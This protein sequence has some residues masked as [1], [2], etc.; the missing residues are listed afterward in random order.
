MKL[1]VILLSLIIFIIGISNIYIY[2]FIPRPIGVRG[3]KGTL[4]D[5]GDSGDEGDMGENGIIGYRGPL[6]IIGKDIGI[7]GISGKRGIPG[8]RGEVG[9]KGFK[10]VKGEKGEKGPPG[11]RGPPGYTGKKG[12][13]G[14]EG[15]PREISSYDGQTNSITNTAPLNLS[16]DRTKCVQVYATSSEMKCPENMAVFDIRARKVSFKTEDSEIEKIICCRFQ[17]ENQHSQGYFD[18]VN[19]LINLNIELAAIG[20]DIESFENNFIPT[21]K[22]HLSLKEYTK[23]QRSKILNNISLIQTLLQSIQNNKSIREMPL[24]N[25]KILL[26]DDNLASQVKV[27]NDNEINKIIEDHESITSYEFYILN[28]M[29][30][31]IT[32]RMRRQETTIETT[33]YKRLLKEVYDFPKN[34]L[35]ELEKR[36]NLYSYK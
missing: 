5:R 12:L 15:Y 3:R 31:L 28:L 27:Y 8:L 20:V 10:G 17:V 35:I 2:Y 19:L 6:G 11:I 30:G 18:K 14:P 33:D 16:A 29:N 32:K 1:I 24:K 13:E 9:P 22:Y 34:N 26:G 25:L 4:G 36:V 23:D 7:R 21:A